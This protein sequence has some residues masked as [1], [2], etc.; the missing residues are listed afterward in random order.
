MVL[1]EDTSKRSYIRIDNRHVY[2]DIIF[3]MDSIKKDKLEMF[4]KLVAVNG[5]FTSQSLIIDITDNTTLLENNLL[6]TKFFVNKEWEE[7]IWRIESECINALSIIID[8]DVKND[9]MGRECISFG[10][11][12]DN[13]TI[14]ITI[15]KVIYPTFIDKLVDILR[16]K[17]I[18]DENSTDDNKD[19]AT[20]DKKDDV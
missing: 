16:K 1:N 6:S 9:D 17:D 13:N 15:P 14:E 12:L 7:Y 4:Y 5:E 18:I 10:Y 2:T 20:E 11:L 3:Q 19:N 8:K